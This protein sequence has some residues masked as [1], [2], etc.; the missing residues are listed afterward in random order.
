ME[1]NAGHSRKTNLLESKRLY[2]KIVVHLNEKTNNVCCMLS[3]LI[4]H[5]EILIRD[6]LCHRST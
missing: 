5:E 3:Y 6:A 2:I 1:L 4:N